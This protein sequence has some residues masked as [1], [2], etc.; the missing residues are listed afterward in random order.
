MVTE[1]TPLDTQ[2]EGRGG[3]RGTHLEGRD[4]AEDESGGGDDD[5]SYRDDGNHLK[6]SHCQHALVGSQTL[7]E[8]VIRQ[9]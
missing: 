3:G 6:W 7:S 2:H 9:R 1:I 8:V 4:G 5:K